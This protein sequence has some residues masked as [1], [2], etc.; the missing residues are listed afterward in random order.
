MM[1]ITQPLSLKVDELERLIKR[2]EPAAFLVPPRLLRRV[3][4]HH[5]KVGGIGLLVPHRK[6]YVIDRESLLRYVL[7]EEL[8]LA[9]ITELPSYIYLLVRPDPERLAKYTAPQALV[10]QWRVLFHLHIDRAMQQKLANGSLTPTMVRDRIRRLGLTEFAEITSVLQQEEYLLAPATSETIYA[11]FVAVYLTMRRFDPA[12]TLHFFPALRDLAAVDA[13][14][15][16]DIDADAIYNATRLLDAD[17]DKIIEVEH[18]API[19]PISGPLDT[20][21]SPCDELSDRLKKALELSEADIENWRQALLP[22]A[23]E[24]PTRVDPLPRRVAYEPH[25]SV[26]S[27]AAT[28]PASYR[29]FLFASRRCVAHHACKRNSRGF[30]ARCLQPMACSGP[31]CAFGYKRGRVR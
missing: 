31:A 28:R 16:E 19:I 7:P 13:L 17:D 18:P 23:A 8:G 9:P 26:G 22:L 20:M 5:R 2:V 30:G 6:G 24:L 11:E 27:T 29:S 15:A 25:G 21:A 14:V 10:K 4:K 12:R 3:I 1:S